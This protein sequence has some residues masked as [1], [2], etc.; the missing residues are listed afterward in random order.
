[1]SWSR[2]TSKWAT[3]LMWAVNSASRGRQSAHISLLAAIETV[4]RMSEADISTAAALYREG[5]SAAA[6]GRKLGFDPQ[7]VL[8][9]LR[10]AGVPIRP[11]PGRNR[12]SRRG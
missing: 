12:N 7:T 8:N 5:R 1:M 11:R 10:S 6:I 9:G 4:R 2:V 3:S